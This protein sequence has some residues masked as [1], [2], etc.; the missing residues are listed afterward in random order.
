MCGIPSDKYAH[1]ICCLL[2]AF[3]AGAASFYFFNLIHCG[4]CKFGA[5]EMGFGFAYIAGV[6]KEKLD[7]RRDGKFDFNDLFADTVG[8]LIGGLLFLL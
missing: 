4:I 2:I 8:G 1:V 6:V 7:E 5:A 3:V